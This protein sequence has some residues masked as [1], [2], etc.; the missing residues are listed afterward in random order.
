MSDRL[1]QQRYKSGLPDYEG[2]HITLHVDFCKSSTRLRRAKTLLL[3]QK[4]KRYSPASTQ[5]TNHHAGLS[6]AKHKETSSSFLA[7]DTKYIDST[8]D[9]W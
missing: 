3:L 7:P 6:P 8:D 5:T 9:P 1:E 4:L 2:I